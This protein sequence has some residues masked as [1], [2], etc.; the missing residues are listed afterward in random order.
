M[1]LF[2]NN[3]SGSIFPTLPISCF[4]F[5]DSKLGAPFQTR[6]TLTNGGDYLIHTT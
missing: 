3:V 5:W 2:I 1:V 6:E 4:C